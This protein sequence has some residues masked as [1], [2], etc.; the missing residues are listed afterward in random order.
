MKIKKTRLSSFFV[1]LIFFIISFICSIMIDK[2]NQRSTLINISRGYYGK[3]QV[4]FSADNISNSDLVNVIKDYP[5]LALYKDDSQNSIRQIYI[6]DNYNHI[7]LESGRF[8][9]P[10]DFSNND[11][12]AVVGKKRADEAK[13]KDGE[14]FIEICGNLYKIIGVV[15][16]DVETQLDDIAIVKL[17]TAVESSEIYKL[18]V[19]SNDERTIF[20]EISGKIKNN[21]G[22]ETR[23]I[24][25][26][27]SGLERMLPQINNEKLYILVVICLLISA[28]T[29]SIEW[30]NNLKKGIAIKRLVGCRSISLV[31]EVI[32]NYLK[33][34]LISGGLGTLFSLFFI[35][36]FK[37]AIIYSSLISVFCGLIVTIPTIKKVLSV[38]VSEILKE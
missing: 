6:S 38:S 5:E 26:E 36:E 22:V 23:E 27:K 3:S 15:G 4:V 25:M 21:Y 14:K 17:G 11:L 10:E 20:E 12:V 8:F 16:V 29:I 9:T 35:N 31:L 32:F 18:D 1:C 24:L 13:E 2:L 34:S 28:I 37:I 19:F 30:A 7:P 33:I